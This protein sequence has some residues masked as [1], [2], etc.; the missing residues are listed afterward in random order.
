MSNAAFT[1]PAGP[2]AGCALCEAAGGRVFEAGGAP[3]RYGLERPILNPFFIALADP[4]I[5]F[6]PL[7]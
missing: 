4:G 1:P 2:V 5:A 7:E 6:P 3:L